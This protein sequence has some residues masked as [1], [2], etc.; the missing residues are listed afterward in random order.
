[1]TSKIIRFWAWLDTLLFVLSLE[2]LYNHFFDSFDIKVQRIVE[3]VMIVSKTLNSL[4]YLRLFG[5]IA[6]LIDIVILIVWDIKYFLLI[7][8]II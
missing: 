5:E 2:I 3:T 1:M 8:L 6:P 7:F 4:Y